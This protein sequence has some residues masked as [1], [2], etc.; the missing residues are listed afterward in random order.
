MNK[1]L[2]YK[3]PAEKWVDGLPLGNGTLGAMVL[4]KV[5]NERIALNEDTLWSGAPKDKTYN[6]RSKDLE[7]VRDLINK[8][9]YYEA[10]E[11]INKKMLN[12]Q[13]EAYQPLGDLNLDF[14]HEEDNYS[15]YTRELDL[16][17]ALV[18]IKYKVKDVEFKR[19]TF[20]SL[21]D[22][23][24]VTKITSN[25]EK[26]INFDVKFSS[27]LKSKS[28]RSEKKELML[29]GIAPI[30]LLPDY[31]DPN[32]L[33]FDEKEE[34][35]TKFCSKVRVKNKDGEVT[36]KNNI[37][38]VRNSS[39]VVLI[40]S[41]TTNFERFNIKQGSLGKD[42]EALSGIIIN[43]AEKYSYDELLENHLKK[44]KELFNRVDFKLGEEALG[45]NRD[46]S[47]LDSKIEENIVNSKIENNLLDS[48]IQNNILDNKIA[49][50]LI[51]KENIAEDKI[52]YE[53]LDQEV[54]SKENL[55]KAEK[56]G[57]KDIEN[58]EDILKEENK[59]VIF[60]EN[61]TILRKEELPTDERLQRL[62]NGE[63][64]LGLIALYFHYG[65]YLLITS[66]M[67]GSEAANL[68]GI[69]NEEVRPPWNCDYTVNI[70]T[71]M[72]YWPA[73]VCNLS[74][75][76]EP[77]MN[78]INELS[79]SGKKTAKESFDCEGWTANHNV[80][81]WR[82]S[83][84]V[85]DS[86]E[87][88]YWPMGGPWLCQ[89]IWEH[90]DFTRDKKFL[91]EYYPVLKGAAKFL[92]SWWKEEGDGSLN[93]YPSTSP[94]NNFLD[95]LGRRCAASKSTTMDVAVSR[96]LFTNVIKA[97]EELE[98]DQDFR[99][100]MKIVLEKLPKYKVNKFGGLQEWCKDFDEY[101]P[102]HRHI[103]H[104]FGLYPGKDINEYENSSLLEACSKTLSRRLKEG[105]G[106]TGWSCAWII[107]FYARLKDGDKA[108]NYVKTLL[109]KLTYPNL[110]CV[111]PP[112][113]IDGNF[114]GTA[115]IAEMLIQSHTDYIEIL[116]SIPK[117]WTSGEVKGLKSRGGFIIDIKWKDSKLIYLKVKSSIKEACKIKYRM[118]LNRDII[119]MKVLR[120][121]SDEEIEIVN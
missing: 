22:K 57:F 99:N 25:K 62:K 9:E 76:H 14:Y 73:E 88:G 52:S 7:E 119:E 109:T 87:W 110:F 90:Y 28:L 1:K 102:G 96:D 16:E 100:K 121:S 81:I 35:G 51:D 94:E 60:E 44:Y 18:T 31:L 114:G 79:I 19:E 4:G 58:K 101:E 56:S 32:S 103:S 112:F 59:E 67:P 98:L 55:Y 83:D 74:E 12:G 97:S 47:I 54:I 6:S 69:W 36:S 5:F 117:E 75:C 78:M 107:N 61:K 11:I 10:Q 38:E 77:L 13:T 27:L 21:K 53:N 41:G 82:Y 24:L 49:N 86:C 43:E 64:D 106:H 17:K 113:Q 3:N 85:V 108:Y 8:E 105:G 15:S 80:D 70:N 63:E 34:I 95:N 46:N 42:E 68:Q 93:T 66:S 37:L 84:T 118:D 120:L 26:A 71:Q 115:G 30:E 91:A 48:K 89:H 72:N 23:V 40:L 39:E 2:F 92:L 33:V 29:K 65:R 50:Y 45:T 104:L 116:P 111:H 20:I